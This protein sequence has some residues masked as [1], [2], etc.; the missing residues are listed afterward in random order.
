[1]RHRHLS[2]RRPNLTVGNERGHWWAYCQACK[3][4]ARL[5]KEHVL[6]TGGPARPL[7]E[8]ARAV[9]TDLVRLHGSD[10]E[11]PVHRFLASKGMDASWLPEL[12]VSP[13]FKR[14]CLQDGLGNWHGRD[15]SE[16]S[17]AKWMHYSSKW[18]GWIMPTTVLVED[19][20]SM[21]KIKRAMIDPAIGVVCTQGTGFSPASVLAL[22]NC[23]RI[24]WAYDGDAAGDEGYAV[25]ARKM[26]AF[27]P[28]QVRARPPEN[29]DPKDMHLAELRALIEGVL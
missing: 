13:S 26:R 7:E 3:Q 9:P 10:W 18:S 12:F 20:F 4:G 22:K 25:G 19:L 16:R 23:N 2:E 28:I 27:G 15:L 21:F 8:P 1:M 6:L 24:I 11:M 17:I 5:A 14:M 29:L